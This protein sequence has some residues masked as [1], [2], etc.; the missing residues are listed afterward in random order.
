[1]P[2]IEK[3]FTGLTAELKV[4]GVVL[5]Y[6]SGVDLT[7]EKSIIEVLQFGARYQEKVP[8]IKDW[9]ADIDGTVALAPGGSQQK[10]YDAF[11][12]DEL[13]TVGIFLDD[14]TYFEGEGY[15]SSFN[16]SGSP[17]DKMNLSS[18][19][20]G[21]GAI[22]LN[23]EP[24][25]TLRMSSGVGGTVTPGGT[26]RVEAGTSQTYTIIPAN[27]FVI[28]QVLDLV[29]NATENPTDITDKVADN[30]LTLENIQNDHNIRVTFKDAP[31]STD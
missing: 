18:N 9:S 15:V 1:M 29:G 3:P 17:D 31:A 24:S 16:I 25:Y 27:G 22:V 30:V 2:Q 28:D 4:N 11:E 6:A 20:A 5:A 13:I 26:T 19:I 7:L 8:A 21:N 14:F 12:N 10:L 23:M